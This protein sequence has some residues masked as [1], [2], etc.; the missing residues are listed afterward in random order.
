YTLIDFWAS[1]CRP[2][3]VENPNVVRA[4]SKYHERG[5]NIISVSLDREGQEDRWVK[6]IADDQ[7]D[8][9]HVSNLQFWQEPIAREYG[10]RSIPQTF[11]IDAQ[12][13]IIDKNL[14]GAALEARLEQLMPRP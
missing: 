11:L 13:R 12:G 14:R 1:W 2:C 3:R 7:M 4:Y 8:W 9:F 6:A 10:V 5:L